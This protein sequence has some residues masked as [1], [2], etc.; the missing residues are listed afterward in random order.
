MP[1]LLPDCVALP[2][3]DCYSGPT[4]SVL[5]VGNCVFFGFFLPE[6]EKSLVIRTIEKVFLTGVYL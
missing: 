1:R 6:G 5:S 3:F 4:L 2:D